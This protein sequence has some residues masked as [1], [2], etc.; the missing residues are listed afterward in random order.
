MRQDSSLTDTLRVGIYN[1][2]STEEEAQRN[3]LNVQVQESREIA[4][5]RKGWI[6]T[7]QYVESESG[8]STRRRNEYQRL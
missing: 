4:E 5:Q 1:R 2:C 7:A 8:T 6:V 3:A